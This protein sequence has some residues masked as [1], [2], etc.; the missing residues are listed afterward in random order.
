MSQ[1][2]E[3]VRR[4]AERANELLNQAN[5]VEPKPAEPAE[6]TQTPEPQAPQAVEPAAPEPASSAPAEP[7]PAPAAPTSADDG[8]LQ[9]YRTLQGVFNA[10]QGR[11]NAEKK[12]LET[13][14]QALE[15]A[16]PA[17]AAAAPAPAP[18]SLVTSADVDTYGPELLDVIGRKATEIAKQMVAEQMQALKPELDR[19]REQVTNVTAQVYRTSEEKFYGELER[20]VPDWQAINT[21]Q[22]WLDWLAE[23]DDLSGV[24]RQRYLDNASQSLDHTRAAR[25]FTAFKDAAGL[26]KPAAAAPAPARATPSPSPRTVGTASA[27][28][29]RE[30]QTGVSRSEIAAHYRRGS[31]DQS[32]R[33]GPEHLAMEQRIATAMATNKII[34]A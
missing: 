4:Q 22:R 1:V 15:S 10:E 11:W 2:P 7:A 5:G 13:R 24:P 34:E 26:N 12:V 25:L 16:R 31:T 23:V 9:K 32:Y 29:H 33:S 19:T 27:P 14:L 3:Q 28:T 30:P 8:Y 21:D 17:P 20:E 6:P 18:T